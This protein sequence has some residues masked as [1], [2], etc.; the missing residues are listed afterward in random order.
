MKYTDLPLEELKYKR[1]D[2][3]VWVKLEDDMEQQYIY[4]QKFWYNK[5]H[6][7]VFVKKDVKINKVRRKIAKKYVGYYNT[8]K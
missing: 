2:K 3:S 1:F 8:I 7:Q 5:L 6:V 4:L